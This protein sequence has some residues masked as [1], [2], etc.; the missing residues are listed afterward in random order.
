MKKQI[1]RNFLLGF[2]LGMAIGFTISIGISLGIGTGEFYSCPP[3]LIDRMGSELGGTIAQALLSGILGSFFC[4][5]SLIWDI[6]EWSLLKQTIVSFLVLTAVMIP[7]AY[8]A[9]WME[10]TLMGL[11]SYVA[12]FALIYMVIWVALFISI[13]RKILKINQKLSQ[14]GK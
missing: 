13:R 9:G 11:L 5:A 10:P 6:E 3:L 14:K 4:A 8:L 7:V 2:P 1:I 12:L